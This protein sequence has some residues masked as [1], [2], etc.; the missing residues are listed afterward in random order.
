VQFSLPAPL[1]QSLSPHG[2]ALAGSLARAFWMKPP[3]AVAG[4]ELRVRTAFAGLSLHLLYSGLL[5]HLLNLHSTGAVAVFL[6]VDAGAD[7]K[8]ASGHRERSSSGHGL[9]GPLQGGE[10]PF[11]PSPELPFAPSPELPFAPAMELTFAP[12]PEL[13]HA[14]VPGV[15]RSLVLSW[16]SER[17][18]VLAPAAGWEHGFALDARREQAFAFDAGREQAFA[19]GTGCGSVFAL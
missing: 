17:K 13:E 6:L 2:P 1:D 12:E 7:Q 5:N 14:F 10:W 4:V 18:Q 19:P 16:E 15:V 8:K 11:D 9:S 3:W